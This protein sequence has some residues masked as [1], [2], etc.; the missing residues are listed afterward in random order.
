MVRA[1]GGPAQAVRRQPR[2]SEQTSYA[3]VASWAGEAS[4]A[5]PLLGV[6]KDGAAYDV[7]GVPDALPYLVLVVPLVTRLLVGVRDGHGLSQL[8]EPFE[9][10]GGLL[11]RREEAL[12]PLRRVR[13]RLRHRFGAGTHK[14]A[15]IYALAANGEAAIGGHERPRLVQG[16]VGLDAADQMQG[17]PLHLHLPKRPV[18]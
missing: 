8:Q 15:Q 1:F 14:A 2:G 13:Y 16:E 9:E 6:D 10:L 7:V 17:G 11:A 12:T 3:S 18:V 5:V 4:H